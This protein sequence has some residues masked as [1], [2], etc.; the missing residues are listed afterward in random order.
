M[1]TSENTNQFNTASSF[2]LFIEKKAREKRMPYMDA[3]LEY[4]A[5]N[6]IDPQDIAS[7]INKS[8]RDKIQ[9]EMIEAN[10]LPK[11]GK[12]DV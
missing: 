3:V 8:L 12:L 2:S 1:L 5:E 10:M 9:M 6:Y 4:C 11:Q 7:M